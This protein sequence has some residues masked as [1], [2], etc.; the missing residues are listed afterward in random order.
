M[1]TRS[2]SNQENFALLPYEP[3]KRQ[4]KRSNYK[5]P[6]T[7]VPTSN[8]NRDHTATSPSQTER[9]ET[10]TWANDESESELSPAYRRQKELEQ[11]NKEDNEKTSSPVPQ[12]FLQK[13]GDTINA[14]TSNMVRGSQAKQPEDASKKD[15]GKS[16]QESQQPNEGEPSLSSLQSIDDSAYKTGDEEEQEI[17]AQAINYEGWGVYDEEDEDESED[18]KTEAAGTYTQ[19]DE[20]N[21]VHSDA[22]TTLKKK[23]MDEIVIP[24]YIRFQMMIPPESEVEDDEEPNYQENY[25][26]IK[27]ILETLTTQ[28]RI[29]DDTAEIISW[30]TKTNFSFLQKD[31]FPSEVAEIAKFFKGFRK[32]MKADRRAYIKFGIHTKKDIKKLEEDMKGWVEL[33]S[34]TINRCLIQ[35][36]DAG[37]V[38][39]IAYT[40]QFTNTNLWK[41]YLM[42]TTSYEWGFKLVPVTSTDKHLKW[43]LRLKAVGIFVPV[44]NVDE[45]KY[46]ISEMMLQDE[47]KLATSNLYQDRFLFIP[48][49]ESIGEDPE[50]VL[51]YQSFVL[52]HKSHTQALKAKLSTHIKVRID[53]CLGSR[54]DPTLSLQRMVLGIMVKDKKNPL[55]DTPLF[56]SVDFVS[57]TNKL[58]MNNK[59]PEGGPAVVFTYYKPVEKEATE[60]V[61][62]LGRYIARTYGK[63]PALA[64]FLPKHWKAT[65]GWRYLPKQG[66]FERPD[67][68]NLITT[69]AYNINHTAICRLQQIEIM[70]QTETQEVD[71]SHQPQQRRSSNSQEPGEPPARYN[72]VNALL[73]NT[74]NQSPDSQSSRSSVSGLTREAMQSELQMIQKIRE[75]KAQVQEKLQ[76]KK[77]VSHISVVEE[78]SDVSSLTDRSVDS[79]SESS[80]AS[81]TS[82]ESALSVS[83][84]EKKI[85]G[86]FILNFDIL[87]KLIKPSMSYQEVKATAEAYFH[88]RQN[89]ETINKDR[90]L[91]TFLAE[92]FPSIPIPCEEDQVS[93]VDPNKKKNEVEAGETTVDEASLESGLSNTIATVTAQGT[94]VPPSD[95]TTP[96][97]YETEAHFDKQQTDMYVKTEPPNSHSETDKESEEP[98]SG[99]NTG[100]QP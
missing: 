68:K 35:S 96:A 63:A 41:E 45:A 81:N 60:M 34:Y 79:L 2:K 61:T 6:R 11:Q 72:D 86:K 58:Y 70:A 71:T 89:H 16:A 65:K 62:G 92:K 31:Q 59:P 51:A 18:D 57:D 10:S 47:G 44:D 73:E 85:D 74:S 56:H 33:Y 90:V 43:N 39:W 87:N 17:E 98:A 93:R 76:E 32:R 55:F 36:D 91:Y 5:A 94:A 20:N 27:K 78:C 77:V 9:V 23:E 37:F 100:N 42:S 25:E 49:E 84:Q 19:Q 30:R 66:T 38:G 83:P 4:P 80:L 8:S 21:T 50:T 82:L 54:I 13:A 14:L 29:F 48:P 28:I 3:K 97:P 1:D 53:S 88:H 24:Q 22:T 52:R 99:H 7:P 67:T 69:L 15:T 40:S 75:Q 46:E 12:S 64:A 95:L 26:R